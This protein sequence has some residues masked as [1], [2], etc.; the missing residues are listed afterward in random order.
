MASP[1]EA[2]L[3][4]LN[5]ARAGGSDFR[6]ALESVGGST[7]TLADELG[8]SQRTVQRWAAYESGTGA[9]ARNPSRSPQAGDLRAMAA[10]EREARALDR[11]ER[12]NDFEADLDVN[13]QE[14]GGKDEGARSGRP[15]QAPL[16]L[17]PVVE[18]YRQNAPMSEVGA[19]FASALG[20]SYGLPESLVISNIDG[21]SLR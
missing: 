9:Q 21:I 3:E 15:M 18:L 7:R 10:S 20:A 6:L 17:R 12:F 19:A 14:A 4:A 8:V 11:L 16:N 13:Y 5:E 1:D 2:F